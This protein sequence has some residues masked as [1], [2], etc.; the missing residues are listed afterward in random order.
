M[1]LGVLLWAVTGAVPRVPLAGAILERLVCA[2]RLADDCR[3]EPAL[4][5]SYGD[6]LAV[7]LRA[8]APTL[9]YEP[10]M[11]ALPVDFRRCRA[12]RC[13]AGEEDGHVIRSR[14]GQRTVAFTHVVD[15]RPDAPRT[16]GFHCSG[17]RRGNLYLQYWFYYPGSATAEGTTPLKPLIRRGS[18]AI[19]KPSYHPDDWESYQVRI[20]PDG[21]SARASSHHWYSYELGGSGFIPG[22]RLFRRPDGTIGLKRRPEPVNGWGPE[23]GTLY[24]SGGSH[25][26][27]AR[28]NRAVSRSTRDGRLI[29][30]PLARIARSDTTAF[31]VTPPWRKEVFFD[32]EYAGTD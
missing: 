22:H 20:G 13:A 32:P 27:N 18:A 2:V 25:A 11:T 19:G 5:A 26:G 31:A 10:G 23:M 7:A 16:A 12:D 3:S 21:R 8:H 28:V 9:L 6:D 14:D 15:C 1:L 29:L 30:I 17:E 4:R 24:V